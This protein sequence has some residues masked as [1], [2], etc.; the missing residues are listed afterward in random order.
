MKYKAGRLNSSFGGVIGEKMERTLYDFQDER[1]QNIGKHPNP[2]S[3]TANGAYDD[4]TTTEAEYSSEPTGERYENFIPESNATSAH[5]EYDWHTFS[6]DKERSPHESEEFLAPPE[7]AGSSDTMHLEYAL[8]GLFAGIVVLL[9]VCQVLVYWKT[10]RGRNS[11]TVSGRR[12]FCR[13]FHRRRNFV[14]SVT[15]EKNPAGFRTATGVEPGALELGR[16]AM[17]CRPSLMFNP[18]PKMIVPEYEY[19][20]GSATSN[21][22]SVRR[23]R[24]RPYNRPEMRQK[25]VSSSSVYVVDA[26]GSRLSKTSPFWSNPP[27]VINVDPSSLASDSINS[28]TSTTTSSSN[29]CARRGENRRRRLRKSESCG[30]VYKVKGHLGVTRVQSEVAC[31]TRCHTV[32]KGGSKEWSSD[33]GTTT[34]ASSNGPSNGLSSKD[35][36]V[37]ISGGAVPFLLEH[38][39]TQLARPLPQPQKS[40]KGCPSDTTSSSA[41]EGAQKMELQADGD[42]KIDINHQQKASS[43]DDDDYCADG[44]GKTMGRPKTGNGA[45]RNNCKSA[46]KGNNSLTGCASSETREISKSEYNQDK[47]G[48]EDCS[49]QK[50]LT[51][52]EGGEVNLNSACSSLTSVSSLHCG[53]SV[54]CN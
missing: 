43:K 53:S 25:S 38:E 23:T 17:P 50:Q 36:S 7:A 54:S 48:I 8:I 35:S 37:E 16:V 30:A 14:C 12:R 27:A 45:D 33:P 4:P 51:V 49:W 41:A 52:T 3:D 2:F 47:G 13:R 26:R 6:H 42:E 32:A 46:D 11:W 29:H 5:S 10:R 39:N 28:S 15:I 9:L 18:R 20:T 44:Y 31:K 21:V 22:S 34:S 19:R 24:S 40:M 1:G